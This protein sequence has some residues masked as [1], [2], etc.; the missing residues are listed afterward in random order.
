VGG[1]EVALLFSSS[2]IGRLALDETGA[3]YWTVG[4]RSSSNDGSVHRMQGR[5]DKVL[6]SGVSPMGAV[7]VDASHVYFTNYEGHGGIRR[8]PRGGGAVEEVISCGSE[9]VP[10]AVRLDPQFVYYRLSSSSTPSI[11]GAVYAA[12]KSDWKVTTLSK[13]NGD[14]GYQY[15]VDVD[16][17]GGVAYWIW[18]A[19]RSPFG[20]FRANTDGSG[21]RAVDSSNDNGWAALRVDDRAAYYWH[22]GALIRRLK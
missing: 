8:V 4:L 7:A 17:N 2:P 22:S 9:C 18:N 5:V 20:I 16:V 11:S 6:A 1:G 19:G 10:Q 3:L 21:F 13:G 15:N 12:S 14:G